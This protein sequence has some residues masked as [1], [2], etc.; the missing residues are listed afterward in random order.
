MCNANG[1]LSEQPTVDSQGCLHR[2][3][4]I[5]M[6]ALLSSVASR[7]CA[8]IVIEENYFPSPNLNVLAAISKGV[9]A[10]AKTLLQQNPPV[11]NGG[12]PAN[13]G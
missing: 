10:V 12:M 9:W 7:D 5:H 3:H 13:I 8:D 11:L 1:M 6:S 2:S 4:K